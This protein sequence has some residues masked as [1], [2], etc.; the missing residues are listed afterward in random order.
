MIRQVKIKQTP[1]GPSLDLRFEEHPLEPVVGILR[2]PFAGMVDPLILYTSLHWIDPKTGWS[3][4]HDVKA[5]VLRALWRQATRLTSSWTDVTRCGLA[6]VE[7]RADGLGRPI[8]FVGTTPGPPISFAHSPGRT[9]GA[10]NLGTSHIGIDS[11]IPDDF[12]ERYPFDRAFH[13]REFS[14]ALERTDGYGESAAALLWSIKE[15]VVKALGCGFRLLD[16]LDL[17]VTMERSTNDRLTFSV[18]LSK[19]AR[20]RL[21]DETTVP[22]AG[23]SFREHG[24]RVS[25]AAVNP[26]SQA[27]LW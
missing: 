20:E 18:F 22:V 15:S 16:P 3:G 10:L 21:P 12:S 25:L 19:A 2:S 27:T 17:S 1:A 23:L 9:W 4:R 26:G 24:V 14:S 6:D 8:A 11:A 7:V 5:R 13:P